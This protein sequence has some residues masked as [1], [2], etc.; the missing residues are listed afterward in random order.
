MTQMRIA[1]AKHAIRTRHFAHNYMLSHFDHV[2]KQKERCHRGSLRRVQKKQA[3][4]LMTIMKVIYTTNHCSN[5]FLSSRLDCISYIRLRVSFF[6]L[7]E[8]LPQDVSVRQL[9]AFICWLWGVFMKTSRCNRYHKWELRSTSTSRRDVAD[10]FV[11]PAPRLS[12]ECVS[13]CC[14]SHL[15][16]SVGVKPARTKCKLPNIDVVDWECASMGKVEFITN[17]TVQ[18]LNSRWNH[19]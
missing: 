9:Y 16:H 2:R 11:S 13:N 7:S 6:H 18:Q 14:L 15:S 12:Q 3:H 1:S 17:L 8:A 19:L 10:A 5:N 4:V